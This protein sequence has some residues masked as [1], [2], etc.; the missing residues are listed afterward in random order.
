[1]NCLPLCGLAGEV[2]LWA[3]SFSPKHRQY[4]NKLFLSQLFNII[5][6]V[7]GF[8]SCQSQLT[9]GRGSSSTLESSL[10]L[11]QQPGMGE[12]PGEAAAEAAEGAAWKRGS[13]AGHSF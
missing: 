4:G 1:M 8:T 10:H 7:L 9:Q 5:F 6:S 13:C 3:F 11:D 12:E 2:G